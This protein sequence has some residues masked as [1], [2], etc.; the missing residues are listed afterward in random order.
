FMKRI[1]MKP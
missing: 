1:L